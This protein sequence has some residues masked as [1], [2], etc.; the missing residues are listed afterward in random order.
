MT[1]SSA[2][3]VALLVLWQSTNAMGTTQERSVEALSFE[4]AS[5]RA[6]TATG[7]RVSFTR[8]TPDG[9]FRRRTLRSSF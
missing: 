1:R 4:V 7:S 3:C 5:I 2:A 6:H 8:V 9:R